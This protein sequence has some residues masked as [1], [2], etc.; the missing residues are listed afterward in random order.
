MVFTSLPLPRGLV[1]VS[2]T[3][4]LT[5]FTSHTSCVVHTCSQFCQPEGVNTKLSA[6]L[7][8]LKL[9]QQKPASLSVSLSR[10]P[11]CLY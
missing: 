4:A 7:G 6:K 11:V 10:S 2:N 8:E 5:S 9:Q 1:Q 3:L